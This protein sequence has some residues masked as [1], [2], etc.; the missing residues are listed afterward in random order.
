VVRVMRSQDAR[1][2]SA[3]VETGATPCVGLPAGFRSQFL[4]ACGPAERDRILFLADAVAHELDRWAARYPQV[5]RVRAYPLALSV[6]A[7]ESYGSVEALVSTARLSL[8]VFTLDDVFDEEVWPEAE[9]MTHVSRYRVI[10]LGEQSVTGG[11]SLEAALTDVRDDLSRYPLF[12]Q[13]GAE[14]AQA[15]GGTIDGMIQEALW[16]QAYRLYGSDALPSYA[17]YV[18][19]G[20]YS[21]GGPPHV[22]AGLI[23]T[24][25]PSTP[26]HLEHLHA[27]ERVACTCI[28]LANDLRSQHKER[29]E[30]NVNSLV[31]LSESLRQCGVSPAE[32]HRQAEARVRADVSTGLASLELHRTSPLTDTGR[33]EATIA[34][35]ARFVCEFYDSHDYHTFVKQE[36]SGL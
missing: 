10:A 34:D 32:T 3:Q 26:R 18:S 27:L 29:E 30:D 6:A 4:D 12:G 13:V 21:I 14:W 9:L 35:I 16:R 23:T 19:T 17:E 1:C 7:A 25:D 2:Q 33:P 5:R 36:Q 11:D 31:I 28:R 20:L 24:G 22:W 15:L 8:W